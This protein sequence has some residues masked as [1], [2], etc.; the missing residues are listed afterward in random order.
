MKLNERIASGIIDIS[1]GTITNNMNNNDKDLIKKISDPNLEV[2]NYKLWYFGRYIGDI[3][4]ILESKNLP[5]IRQ[6]AIGVL[7]GSGVTFS[8]TPFLVDNTS[9]AVKKDLPEQMRELYDY[10]QELKK[11]DQS[12]NGH[13]KV[14]LQ[15]TQKILKEMTDI[16]KQSDKNS[17]T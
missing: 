2:K 12:K 8:S 5:F 11:R 7:T 3:D 1:T 6:M 16:L 10:F 15:R 4:F 13:K 14:S 9:G 17:M